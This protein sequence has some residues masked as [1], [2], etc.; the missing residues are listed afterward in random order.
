MA[1]KPIN[2]EIYVRRGDS[3]DRAIRRF[4]KKVKKSGVLENLIKGKYYEKPSVVRNRRNRM[5]KRV[6]ERENQARKEEESNLYKPKPK[7][8]RK[9]R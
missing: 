5:R 7:R 2:V 9:R 3:I 6:I 1:G 8:R 4:S